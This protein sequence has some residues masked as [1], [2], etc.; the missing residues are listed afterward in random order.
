MDKPSYLEF[1]KTKYAW[2]PDVDYRAHPEL[3]RVG[4]G[5][6]GV[7]I[8]EPYK[9]ELVPLWR[10]KTPE[11]ARSSSKAIYKAFLA[12]LVSQEYDPAVPDLVINET[13]AYLMNTADPRLFNAAV[14]GMTDADLNILRVRFLA[15]MPAGWLRDRIALPP[16]VAASANAASRPAPE[17]APVRQ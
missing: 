1:D 2:K 4:K 8:C 16:A 17:G 10:F 3:Y 12:Y 14:V 11:I 5:E 7:L 6:Q 13:Q 9:G 15:G